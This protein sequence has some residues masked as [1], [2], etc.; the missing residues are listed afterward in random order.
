MDQKERDK[1]AAIWVE[2]LSKE[3]PEVPVYLLQ[4]MVETYLLAPKETEEI[5]Y[6]H[7]EANKNVVS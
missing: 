5:I 7:V 3:N 2:E 4:T 1:K 6:R